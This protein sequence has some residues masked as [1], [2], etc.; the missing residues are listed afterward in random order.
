VA[1][2]HKHKKTTRPRV[3]HVEARGELRDEPDWDRFA[4]HLL[5]YVRAQREAGRLKPPK[6]RRA[7]K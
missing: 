7:R 2:R 5:Q 3:T 4:F 6:K 1:Q